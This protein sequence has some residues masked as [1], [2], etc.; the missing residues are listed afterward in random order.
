MHWKE[1]DA[2]RKKAKQL[3]NAGV[4]SYDDALER[5]S[6][7][8]LRDVDLQY[9]TSHPGAD[10][11]A[12]TWQNQVQAENPAG[13]DHMPLFQ[14]TSED[15]KDPNKY[16]DTKQTAPDIYAAANRPPIPGTISSRNP[17]LT[18]ILTGNGKSLGN[19]GIEGLNR[20]LDLAVGDAGKGLQVPLFTLTPDESAA[21][22]A[23]S[24]AALPVGIEDL[25]GL[26]GARKPVGSAG[27]IVATNGKGTAAGD[28][29][30]ATANNFYRDGSMH[31]DPIGSPSGIV[32]K[33][34]PNRTTTALG[35]FALDMNDVINS[36]LGYP[37]T[38]NFGDKPGGFNV[39]NVP[40]NMY[41]T[42]DQFWSEVN[43]P[44]LDQAIQRGDNIVPVTK[45]TDA[46]L[47]RTLPDGTVVRSG[48]G[49]ECDYLL[50]HGYTYDRGT[51]AM[52]RKGG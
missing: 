40:D 1:A 29:S 51:S 43:Q 34:D 4:T 52:I 15:Y 10:V 3:A 46:V 2:I 7:Q 50:Q 17:S 25:L 6:S 5:L 35:S 24:I 22:F 23:T 21:A 31:M 41:K 16:A 42:P 14:A 49:R 28:S 48:F 39:L 20:G 9:A 45:P 47:N 26:I 11:Q 27:D 38:V 44:F 30:A 8:A 33:P 37:K 32:V 18:A 36:Q 19:L 12:Q 13:F